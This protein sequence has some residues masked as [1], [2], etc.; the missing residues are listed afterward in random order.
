MTKL[1]P[2]PDPHPK[3]PRMKVP[4]GATDC[5]FHVYGPADHYPMLSN[6][7]HTA[8]DAPASAARHLFG[9]LGIQ[10]AVIVQ[11]SVYGTDNRRQ[12]DAMSEIGIEMRAVVIVAP[13]ISDGEMQRLHDAGARGVRMI[14]G[15][16][17]VIDYSNL[18]RIADRNR[19][20]GW[21]IEF[22][23]WPE[24]IVEFEQ[25]M[26]K[27]SCPIVIDHLAFMDSR[28]GLQQPGFQSLL[29]LAAHDHCWLKLS[30]GNRLSPG[31]PPYPDL[32]PYVRKI[33]DVGADRLVWGSDWPHNAFFGRMPNTTD[34]LDLLLDWIP[35]E[36][37]RNQVLFNNPARLYG[38]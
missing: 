3:K 14:G 10:R 21:H 16:R 26:T 27:L 2:P 11:P 4:V 9:T 7:D 34:L 28:T 33:I 15:G 5:H 35:H 20:L 12:L 17:G 19:E 1:V 30:A 22:L 29:R 18:E 23:I 38:F 8:P 25:R 13:D 32:L 37:T 6:R 36:Q 31:D 24:H